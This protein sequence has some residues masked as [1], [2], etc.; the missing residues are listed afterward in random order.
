MA[1]RMMIAFTDL[2]GFVTMVFRGMPTV[3][4]GSLR[5]VEQ[6]VDGVFERGE[7]ERPGNEFDGFQL[8]TVSLGIAEEEGRGPRHPDFLPLVQ[9]GR[10]LV[11]VF[12]TAKT[13]FEG[14]AIQPQ[15]LGMLLQRLGLE[16]LLVGEQAGVHRLALALVVGTPKGLGGFAGKRVDGLQREVARYI[17]ELP[18][19]NIGLLKLRQ[20]LTDVSA[21]E[22]S[23]VVNEFNE[24]EL[25]MLVAFGEGVRYI[26]HGVDIPNRRALAPAGRQKFFDLLHVVAQRFL[27]GLEGLYG[28]EHLVE[29][30]AR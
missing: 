16:L 6:L 28:L 11:G 20:R 30:I 4:R 29:L 27:S 18:R 8:G 12:A 3:W 13:G 14:L 23:L 17:V 1:L 9:T 15:G 2:P 21:T 25:G 24:R 26:D 5:R 7:R 22:R 19:G 10:D